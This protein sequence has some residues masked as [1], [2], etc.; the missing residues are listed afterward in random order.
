LAADSPR[1]PI[2]TS[3]IIELAVRANKEETTAWSVHAVGL[4]YLRAGKVDEAIEWL[5]RSLDDKRAWRE[6]EA[7]CHLVNLLGLAIANQKA[8]REDRAREW[9]QRAQ[10][11]LQTIGKPDADGNLLWPAHS[12]DLLSVLL[13]HREAKELFEKK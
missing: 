12:H 3:R 1:P 13:L 10:E 2:D 9:W 11:L 4:A 5:E 6:S 8:H 7:S